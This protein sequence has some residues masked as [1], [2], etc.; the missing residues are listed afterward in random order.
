MTP[1][2]I[3]INDRADNAEVTI[4]LDG[5]M[6]TIAIPNDIPLAQAEKQIESQM[7]HLA[8]R[9]ICTL[10]GEPYRSYGQIATIV[11]YYQIMTA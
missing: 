5:V 2:K 6:F 7:P 1:T 9:G 8:A 11:D 10:I 4:N 3:R